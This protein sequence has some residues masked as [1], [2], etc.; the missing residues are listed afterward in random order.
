MINDLN[1]KM[2]NLELIFKK[3][4]LLRVFFFRIFFFFYVNYF[5]MI[6]YLDFCLF[7]NFSNENE[8]HI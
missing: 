1:I 4:F 2:C 3:K 8:D 7:L 6:Y 5:Q